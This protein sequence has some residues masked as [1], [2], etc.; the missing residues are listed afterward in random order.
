V[1]IG[2]GSAKT[3]GISVLAKNGCIMNGV[4]V[5]KE[6]VSGFPNSEE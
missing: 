2:L 3:R 4:V 6:L 1:A 5:A